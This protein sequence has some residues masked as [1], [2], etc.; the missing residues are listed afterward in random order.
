MKIENL[1]LL[2]LKYINPNDILDK[3][4]RYTIELLKIQRKNSGIQSIK[5]CLIRLLKSSS[6]QINRENEHCL[7]ITDIFVGKRFSFILIIK[8]NNGKVAFCA[9]VKQTALKN[10]LENKQGLFDYIKMEILEQ[11]FKEIL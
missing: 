9:F 3:L 11:A 6:V 7:K 5:D 1:W 10:S 8:E 4:K 2:T